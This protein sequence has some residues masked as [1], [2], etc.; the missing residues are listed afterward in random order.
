MVSSACA[1]LASNAVALNTAASLRMNRRCMNYPLS[2]LEKLLVTETAHE[3][4]AERLNKLHEDDQDHDHRQ[5][6]FQQKPLIPVANA[7][8]AQ[9]TAAD[10]TRHGRIPNQRYERNRQTRNHTR[11]RLRDR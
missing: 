11:Q 10:C 1:T 4:V 3:P 2:F 9:T 6:H 7:Q 5:H 8:V